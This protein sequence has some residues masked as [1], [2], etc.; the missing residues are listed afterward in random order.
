MMSTDRWIRA[1]DPDRDKVV[2][3]LGDAYAVGRLSREELLERCEAAYSAATLG[4]LRDV[5]ADLPAPALSGLPSE[6]VAGRGK[7]GRPDGQTYFQMTF[8]WLLVLVAG[9]AGRL[10]P[11]A[12]LVIAGVLVI[13]AFPLRRGFAR[14]RSRRRYRQ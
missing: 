6:T 5:V 7:A 9:L 10:L 12:A 11:G 2:D 4:E 13:L 14:R 1:S 3:L 8:M